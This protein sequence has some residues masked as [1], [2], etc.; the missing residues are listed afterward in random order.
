MSCRKI[1]MVLSL[2]TLI[3]CSD[4]DASAPPASG[5]VSFSDGFETSSGELND[6][7]GPERWSNFQQVS[8]AGATNAVNLATSQ[9]RSGEYSLYLEASPSSAP[10]SKMGI[11][12]GGFEFFNKEAIEISAW[13]YVEGNENLQNLTLIDL[14]C[15]QCWD[16][17]VPDNQCPG[18]RL[19]MSGGNDY[20][21]IE[22]GKIGLNSISQ[23]TTRFPRDKWV[24]IRWILDLSDEAD[25]LSQLYIN[26]QL[27]IEEL[28]INMPNQ[29]IFGSIFAQENIDFQLQTPLFYERVQFGIT[30]NSTGNPVRLY[31]DDVQINSL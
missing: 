22:R 31:L 23:S 5:I 17:D 6:L 12:K 2:I 11:E 7:F 14:E 4:D 3:A 20:L 15:C 30:A 26:E 27:V 25:G 24:N 16:P 29:E 10:V 8:P 21:V 13:F 19:Q 1:V 28:G 9:Q 18:V